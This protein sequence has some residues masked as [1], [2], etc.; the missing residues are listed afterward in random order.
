MKKFLYNSKIFRDRRRDLRKDQTEA[1][2]ILWNNLRDRKLNGSKFIRQYSAGPY[3]LDFYNPENRLAIEVDGKIH[4][5][6]DARIY[7]Q[8]RSE[9][10]ES[11]D[12]KIVRFKNEEV[13]N[14][15]ENVLEKIK[16]FLPLS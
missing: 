8:E 13:I 12:I 11:L 2:K 4:E 9:Y 6:I 3:I 5:K 7:D 14:N 15:I 10:L 1:E 16:Q